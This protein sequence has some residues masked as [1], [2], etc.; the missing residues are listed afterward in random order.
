MVLDF[1]DVYEKLTCNVISNDL[2]AFCLTYWPFRLNLKD[3]HDFHA[4]GF[5]LDDECW[6]S[7]EQRVLCVIDQALR[8]RTKLVRVIWRN[9][10]SGCNFENVWFYLLVS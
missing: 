8:G 10:S 7:Y 6:R 5:C 2:L 9:A 4:S 3:N 1:D